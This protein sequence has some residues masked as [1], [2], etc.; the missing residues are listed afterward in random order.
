MRGRPWSK[1]CPTSRS[2]DHTNF[3]SEG[4]ALHVAVLQ[5]S[6]DAVRVLLQFGADR[7]IQVLQFERGIEEV[8]NTTALDLARKLEFPDLVHILRDSGK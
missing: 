2:S 1:S 5:G 4:T 6:V 8:P 7:T 3:K